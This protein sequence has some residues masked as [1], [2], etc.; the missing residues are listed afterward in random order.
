MTPQQNQMEQQVRDFHWLLSSFVDG[1]AHV[2][3]AVAVSSDG[4]LLGASAGPDRAHIEQL[5]AIAAGLTSLT[6]GAADCFDYGSVELVMTRMEGGF[7]LLSRISDGSCLAVLANRSCDVSAV[8]YEMTLLVD[9][10]GR[11][12]TPFLVTELKN[13]LTV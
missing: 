9:R 10:I 11:L 6:T 7:L 3:E 2:D 12:L 4:F 13:A 8:S 5:S 1:T